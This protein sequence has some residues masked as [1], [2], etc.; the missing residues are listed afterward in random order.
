[1]KTVKLNGIEVTVTD[2]DAQLM[3][4][5]AREIMDQLSDLDEGEDEL[6]SFEDCWNK[7]NKENSYFIDSSNNID[8]FDSFGY[9][10]WNDDNVLPRKELAR[11]VQLYTQLLIVAEAL[12]DGEVIPKVGEDRW[13]VYKNDEGYLNINT[14]FEDTYMDILFKD[15][16]TAE[17]AIDI[18]GDIFHSFFDIK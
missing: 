6:T 7:V 13:V 10:G 14:I 18:A 17:E 9:T 16:A 2:E 3:L 12:N 1:M 5:Q 8:S 11:K 15:E 4:Q